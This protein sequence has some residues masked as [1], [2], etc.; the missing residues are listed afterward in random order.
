MLLTGAVFS[1]VNWH[2]HRVHWGVM[3]ASDRHPVFLDRL[4]VLAAEREDKIA[5]A[6]AV[7][8]WSIQSA[9]Q[10][11]EYQRFAA[12][13][14]FEVRFSPALFATVFFV[15]VIVL[16]PTGRVS[17]VEKP[18]GGRADGEDS[19]AARGAGWRG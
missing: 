3:R 6:E 10:L 5:N 4:R 8:E 2:H 1:P 13:R 9:Q 15:C 19:S 14:I 16:G 18:N 17:R 7:K 11:C 12:A